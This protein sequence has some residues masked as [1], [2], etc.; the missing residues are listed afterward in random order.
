M[1][2][3]DRYRAW[4]EG[5]REKPL[6]P[7]NMRVQGKGVQSRYDRERRRGKEYPDRARDPRVQREG[8]ET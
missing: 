7:A 3:W 5:E 2:T 6:R 4:R 8:R 1:E